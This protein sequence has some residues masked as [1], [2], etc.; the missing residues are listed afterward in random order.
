MKNNN[1]SKHTPGPWEI[2]HPPHGISDNGMRYNACMVYAPKQDRGS[3]FSCVASIS[4]LWSHSTLQDIEDDIKS[5]K[6]ENGSMLKEGLANA[7]LIASAPDLLEALKSVVEEY[8]DGYGLNYIDQVRA[9]IAKAEGTQSSKP[10][11]EG[12][13]K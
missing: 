13:S 3:L 12:K 11:R 2:G 5:A 6:M 4:G 9:A 8:Q 10:S 7:R 1:E